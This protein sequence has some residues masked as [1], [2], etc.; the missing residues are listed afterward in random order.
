MARRNNLILSDKWITTG[1][2]IGTYRSTPW[3]PEELVGTDFTRFTIRR[4]NITL[5]KDL[6]VKVQGRGF[7]RI[8]KVWDKRLDA[9]GNLRGTC[10]IKMIK[11]EME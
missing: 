2:I 9:V 5:V 3:V 7:G 10:A 6:V 8:V 4:V 1:F 11:P